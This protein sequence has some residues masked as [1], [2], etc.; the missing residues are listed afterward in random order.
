[1][2][3]LLTRLWRLAGGVAGVGAFTAPPAVVLYRSVVLLYEY[4][5]GGRSVL[6]TL[7]GL[8]VLGT[9]ALTLVVALAVWRAVT[10]GH[11]PGVV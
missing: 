3:P 4:V 2:F 5:A 7:V 11:P 9:T 8:L 10:D 1:M 6:A